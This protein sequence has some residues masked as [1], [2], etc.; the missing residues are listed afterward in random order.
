ML[1][2]TRDVVYEVRNLRHVGER[3]ES[4]WQG[5]RLNAM[6]VPDGDKRF[7][8]FQRFGILLIPCQ[9]GGRCA[10]LVLRLLQAATSD[11]SGH[12]L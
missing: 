6:T 11:R 1:G 3:R 4:N 12:P 10:P 9:T 2:E 5:G 8:P 7:I